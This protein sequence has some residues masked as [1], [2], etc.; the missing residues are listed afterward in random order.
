MPITNSRIDQMRRVASMP[1]STGRFLAKGALSIMPFVGSHIPERITG[2]MEEQEYKFFTTFNQPSDV[3]TKVGVTDNKVYTCNYFPGH[4][5][6]AKNVKIRDYTPI[7]VKVEQA[8]NGKLNL[9]S[10]VGNVGGHRRRRTQS[11]RVNRRRTQSKRVNRRRTP[12]KRR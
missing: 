1:G 7:E 9:V 6:I 4:Y 2:S 12:A 10:I 8:A 3:A 5:F 11:K